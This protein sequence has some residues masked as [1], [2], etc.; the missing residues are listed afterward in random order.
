MTYSAEVWVL[1]KNEIK[2]K[3]DSMR[4]Y[5]ES[6]EQIELITNEGIKQNRNKKH[7]IEYMRK[8]D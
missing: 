3:M 5:V 4:S 7:D 6:Y 1:S 8:N 2:T